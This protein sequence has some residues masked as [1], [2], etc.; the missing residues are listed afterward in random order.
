MWSPECFI[1]IPTN[2]MSLWIGW[3]TDHKLHDSVLTLGGRLSCLLHHVIGIGSGL[4]YWFVCIID[5]KVPIQFANVIYSVKFRW[6]GYDAHSTQIPSSGQYIYH[7]PS[8]GHRTTNFISNAILYI[9]VTD[10]TG[11]WVFP[12]GLRFLYL[13]NIRNHITWSRSNGDIC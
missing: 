7:K 3:Y 10:C 2:P 4:N 1:R 6:R 12:Q 11:Y 9:L 8:L 5:L 13:A